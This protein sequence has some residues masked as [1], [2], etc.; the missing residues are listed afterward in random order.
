M[1]LKKQHDSKLK[2]KNI[3]GFTLVELLVV[4]AIIGILVALLLPAVQAAREAARRAQCTNNLKQMGL[5][6]IGYHDTNG[7]YP[8]SVFGAEENGFDPNTGIPQFEEQ[9]YGWMVALLPNVEEQPLFDQID[10]DFDSSPFLGVF[11]TTGEIIPEGRTELGM[12][13]CPSSIMPSHAPKDFQGLTLDSSLVG[14]AA[15][16]YRACAGNQDLQVGASGNLYEGFG[17]FG[18]R[19][20]LKKHAKKRYIRIKDIT[21]GLSKTI[22][23]GEGAY[24]PSLGS[25]VNKWPVWMGG[26]VEDESAHF[27]TKAQNIINCGIRPKSMDAFDEYTGDACAFSWHSGGAFFCFGDGSVHFLQESIDFK[28]FRNLGDIAD[29]E[30]IDSSEL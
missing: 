30:I 26:V 18:T 1:L 15:N 7:R 5:G 21:D 27:E 23:L 12:V 8:F 4:I 16:D 11:A 9:G 19:A 14:Y 20:E 3:G 17:M 6:L 22:A 25:D 28:T 24:V 13:R 2:F 29:G 10:P